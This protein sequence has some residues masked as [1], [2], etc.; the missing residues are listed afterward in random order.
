MH[1]DVAHHALHAR[2]QRQ[3]LGHLFVGGLALLELGRLLAR[4]DESRVGM[5]GHLRQRHRLARRRRNQLGDAVD[6]AVAHAQHAADVAQRRLG[7][8]GA[9]GDDLAH[10]VAAVL[11]LHV[12][13]DAVA[14][15]LAEVDV[16]IGHRLAFGIQ[17]PLEQQLVA[18]RVEVGDE[19]GVG[20]QRTGARA[21]ARADRAAVTLGPADEVA[22][23]QEVAREVHR[24]DG[25]DLE[26]QPLDVARPLALACRR[27]GVELRQA[28]LKA[29]E[30]GL[31]EV[32][33][34]RHRTAVVE[35]RRREVRQL[36]LAQRQR[37]AAAA[38]DLHRVGQRR[39]QVGETQRHLGARLEIL[40]AREAAHAP[41]VAQEFAFGDADAGL[42]RLVVVGLQELHRMGGHHRQ[43]QLGRQR[44]RGAHVGLVG[45]HAG[46]L[47]LDIEA[48]REQLCEPLR[49]RPCA[50]RVAGQQRAAQRAG[51]GAGQRDQPVAM[52]AQ[53]VP[54]QPGLV[55]VHVARPAARQ[56]LAQVQ[57]A[58]PVL[59]Q[60]QQPGRHALAGIG[61][62]LHPDVGAEDRLHAF[63]AAGFVEL[64]GAE[65][66]GEV[67]DGE[68]R[69][70]VG[71]RRGGRVGDAQGT[72]DDRELGVRAQVDEAHRGIVGSRPRAGTRLPGPGRRAASAGRASG[73]TAASTIASPRFHRSPR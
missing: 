50:R 71:A 52:L 49:H 36:R 59:H 62:R 16:E 32:G 12:V 41:G 37:Q 10:R 64:D 47:Q 24:H 21:A 43:P 4:V 6:V 58:A 9:E 65:Q 33:L 28:P 20:H 8:H 18:Q 25:G 61:Q 2:G 48:T 38:R 11:V 63:A 60:Q 73:G 7:R 44:H 56:Q 3:Q 22:D 69:L 66:V 34:D 31:P 68:R 27:V 17:E 14:V 45:R 51:I 26:L 57:P 39:R 72:V 13:D 67:G 23:D 53:P 54:L 5:L 30:R 46:A 35:P 19:Q 29:L 42:V 70:A 40:L 1:A 15:G 55:A